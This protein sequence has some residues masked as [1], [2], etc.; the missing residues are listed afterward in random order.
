MCVDDLVEHADPARLTGAAERHMKPQRP[1]YFLR[2]QQ[3][4]ARPL[5]SHAEPAVV[6]DASKHRGYTK[7]ARHCTGC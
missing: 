2:G 4:R 1:R 5:S 7:T 3:R 6:S